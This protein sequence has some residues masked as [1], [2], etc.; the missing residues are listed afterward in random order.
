MDQN[1]Y[2]FSILTSQIGKFLDDPSVEVVHDICSSYFIITC[3]DGVDNPGPGPIPELHIT[4]ASHR[5]TLEVA[6]AIDN[7]RDMIVFT[8]SCLY[9]LSRKGLVPKSLVDGMMD[10]INSYVPDGEEPLQKSEIL[11][12]P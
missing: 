8:L 7:R 6:E 9:A 2:I 10:T 12:L 11:E 1:R 3:P 4:P 5:E